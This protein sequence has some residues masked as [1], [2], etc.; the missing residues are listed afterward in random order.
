MMIE[1]SD[2]YYEMTNEYKSISD[3]EIKGYNKIDIGYLEINISDGFEDK[4]VYMEFS[5]VYN[6]CQSGEYS[7]YVSEEGDYSVLVVGTFMGELNDEISFEGLKYN[8]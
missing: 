3:L 2:K 6:E 4:W 8:G 5:E 7:K 1:L